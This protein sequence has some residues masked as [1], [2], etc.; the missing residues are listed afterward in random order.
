MDELV[1]QGQRETLD[2]GDPRINLSG[3]DPRERGLRRTHLGRHDRLAHSQLPSAF[4]QRSQETTCPFVGLGSL[5]VGRSLGVTTQLSPRRSYHIRHT[6]SGITL[7]VDCTRAIARLSKA[8][9]KPGHANAGFQA[10]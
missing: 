10:A 5:R 9:H 6:L 8:R 2:G 4:G 7:K 1:A 3:L